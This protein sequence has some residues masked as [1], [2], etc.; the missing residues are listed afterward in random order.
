MSN[1]P[2]MLYILAPSFSGS[3]LLT[4]LLSQH[5]DICSVGELKA[6]SLGNVSAYRCSCGEF[7]G[8][9]AFWRRVTELSTDRLGRFSI[10][11][12][13]LAIRSSV[14]FYNRL[15]GAAVRGR[16]AEVVR[17]CMIEYLPGL[18]ANLDELVLRNFV[19]TQVIREIQGGTIF[20]DGSKDAPRLLYFIRSG[21]WDIR[22][23][24]LQRD[25][26]GVINSN[27][28]H[29]GVDF[30]TAAKGWVRAMAELQNTREE[31]E[32]QAVYDLNYEDVCRS[33]ANTF[34]ELW[35]WLGV[36]HLNIHSTDLQKSRHHI[37]GNAM[38]L[39]N[40]DEIVLDESWRNDLHSCD[41]EH[42]E[43]RLSSSNR[44]LI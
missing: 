3:T 7:I 1:K 33:P 4:F 16:A 34:A 8:R 21:L 6:T 15:L 44:H 42:F 23:I 22:V 19:L 11:E 30:S 14:S 39:S 18:K 5:P 32:D 38:R 13:G 26:R 37:L 10:E 9:C 35:S 2:R 29:R 40:V 36:R 20:L 12:S 41:L 25:G 24:Y 27:M 17:N 31:L 43:R 28:K